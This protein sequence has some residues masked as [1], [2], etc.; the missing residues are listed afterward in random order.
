MEYIFINT[1]LIQKRKGKIQRKILNFDFSV[2]I[3]E[4]SDENFDSDEN[5]N[6]Q[7]SEKR[8]RKK[9]TEIVLENKKTKLDKNNVKN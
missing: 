8:K 2:V 7:N 5:E 9:A 4:S 6:Q 3:D 1:K